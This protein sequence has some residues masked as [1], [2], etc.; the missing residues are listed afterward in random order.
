VIRAVE[1]YS[2]I[3]YAERPA[4]FRWQRERRAVTRV[5]TEERTPAGKRF[6]VLDDRTE[7]FILTYESLPDRWSIE[8][9]RKAEGRPE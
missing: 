1:C 8:P 9:A 7:R 5:I 4:A 3:E 2:G 6:L